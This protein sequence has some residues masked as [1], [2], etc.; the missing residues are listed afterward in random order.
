[1]S[2]VP[3]PDDPNYAAEMLR[4]REEPHT[5]GSDDVFGVVQKAE[6]QSPEHGGLIPN[7]AEYEAAQ[8]IDEP[9]P[10]SDEL[11][12]ALAAKAA[13]ELSDW[14][15]TIVNDTVANIVAKLPEL[16]AEHIAALVVAET[17]GWGR[18]TLLATL[19]AALSEK[20]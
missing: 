2:L 9:A 1:M 15:V 4:K 6:V 18:V 17:S 7:F 3:L 14:A 20:K 12:T 19:N 16:T 11:T 13:K 8:A 10:I 5:F